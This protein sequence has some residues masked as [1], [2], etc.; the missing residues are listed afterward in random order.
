MLN[1][2]WNLKGVRLVFV[3]KKILHSVFRSHSH[4]AGWLFP[5]ALFL[6]LLLPKEDSYV[7]K[8]DARYFRLHPARDL[9]KEKLAW[10]PSDMLRWN[11]CPVKAM[12][13]AWCLRRNFHPNTNQIIRFK[14]RWHEL[15]IC[16]RTKVKTK[17]L[18]WHPF[19]VAI[20]VLSACML[21]F[22]LPHLVMCI[23]LLLINL[24]VSDEN[25][26]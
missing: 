15:W 4:R 20:F 23:L 12:G 18:L 1:S 7:G 21:L 25:S 26:L 17:K 24:Q 19:L 13:R 22:V 2:Y 9:R 14:K 5:Y 16:S 8:R 3:L 6:N 10:Q 11:P